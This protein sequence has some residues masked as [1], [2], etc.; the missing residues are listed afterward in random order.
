MSLEIKTQCWAPWL[1]LDGARAIATRIGLK[2]SLFLGS[3]LG[4]GDAREI[5][6]G[7]GHRNQL[8][9]LAINPEAAQRVVHVVNCHDDLIA[10]LVAARGVIDANKA[11]ITHAR[12]CAAIDK[13]RAAP[14]RAETKLCDEIGERQR[15]HTIEGEACKDKRAAS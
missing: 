8:V 10:A 14:C 4:V 7:D 5:F 6:Q 11:P 2:P 15:C 12:V 3:R 1:A 13:A 9:A